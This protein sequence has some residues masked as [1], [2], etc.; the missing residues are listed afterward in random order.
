MTNKNTSSARLKMETLKE[1]SG[2]SPKVGDVV[3]AHYEIWFGDG[4]GSS[5][6]DYMNDVYKSNLSDSTY[7]DKPF[8]GPVKFVVGRQTPKDDIYARGDSIKGL[9]QAFLDMRVGEKRKLFIP[10]MLAYG[11]EGAS[12]FHTFHGFRTPPFQDLHMN[13]ELVDILGDVEAASRHGWFTDGTSAKE[14]K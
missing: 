9:D 11:E 6:Y 4:V 7:E 13:V 12:S 2:E 10:H 8:S 14:E 1:G 5:E 3:L